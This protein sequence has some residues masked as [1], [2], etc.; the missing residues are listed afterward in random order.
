LVSDSKGAAS[1]ELDDVETAGLK[2]NPMS[3]AELMAKL[4]RS[5]LPVPS[6][7]TPPT[8]SGVLATRCLLLTNMFNPADETQ[9]DWDR[10]IEADVKEECERSY[11][12]VRHIKVI[13]ESV[14]HVYLKFASLDGSEKALRSLNGR[15]FAS[16]QVSAT[17]ISGKLY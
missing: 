3:R 7:P 4:A 14:G 1:T 2:L 10:E 6:L 15:W 11:G 9:P 13:K 12:A 16:R 5:D 17:Y 8:S